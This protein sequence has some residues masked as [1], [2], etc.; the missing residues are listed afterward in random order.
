[1]LKYI[2]YSLLL[3]LLVL[4]SACSEET[5]QQL[6]SQLKVMPSAYGDQN[7]LTVISDDDIWESDIGDTI[8]FYYSAPY[9]IL[10]QPEPIL[11]LRHFSTEDL[12]KD[13]LRRELRAY[14]IIANLEDLSSPTTQFVKNIIGDVQFEKALLDPKYNL[15]QVKDRWA[16]GQLIVFQ[17][18]RN[19]KELI[20]NLKKNNP[21]I[22]DK[23]QEHDIPKLE[24]TVFLDARNL[25]LEREVF[26][27]FGIRMRLPKAY[28]KALGDGDM[29]WLRDEQDNISNNIFIRRLP[30]TDV[31]QIS[32]ENIK[33]IRD[34]L[35][36]YVSTQIDNT[37]MRINDED[38]PMFTKVTQV[39]NKYAL[40]ARGIWEIANDYMG[41]PFVSYLI[42]NPKRNEL[43]F[44]DGFIHAP[45]ED[46]RNFMQYIEHILSTV[47]LP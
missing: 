3:L 17:F 46:K 14:L 39:D 41:G 31:S 33:S 2:P 34:S 45:G 42:H 37:Y 7:Q 11:D 25:E 8:D 32:K 5:Q 35:G 47:Q 43:V 38:L 19:R 16:K 24:A 9:L 21:L 13:P 28:F 15:I 20:D 6:N 26:D 23:V 40:E 36:L 10:P 29:Y 4:F 27:N 44:I 22:I 18:G 30:Y 12:A 1:M